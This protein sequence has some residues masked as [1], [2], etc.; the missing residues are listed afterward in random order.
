[1]SS[2][3]TPQ[4]PAGTA[5]WRRHL[6]LALL[7]LSML[8]SFVDRNLLSTMFGPL[9]AELQLSDAQL[10]FLSGVAF[11]V[12]NAI[13]GVSMGYMADRYNRKVLMSTAV[14]LWSL[15]TALQGVCTSYYELVLMR[16]MVGIGEAA[17]G[18]VAHSVICDLFS[19]ER[20]AFAFS[21]WNTSIPVGALGGLLLGGQLTA[22][23]GWRQVFIV[24]G[25]PGLGLALLIAVFAYEPP[26]GV[27]ERLQRALP[28]EKQHLQ[29][30]QGDI[31]EQEQDQLL[32]GDSVLTAP[33]AAAAVSN[34][35]S[36]KSS[37]VCG[38]VSLAVAHLRSL[39]SSWHLAMGKALLLNVAIGGFAW[40]P[41]M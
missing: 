38:R 28:A 14:A 9:S 4:P 22:H 19:P 1:M 33:G 27:G 13:F 32:G 41:T 26:R 29:Q 17:A 25:L 34:T 23:L 8:A 16:M 39:R 18:P 30:Q 21:I 7:T 6:T 10:G 15:F 31:G 5:E 24:V 3:P 37:S 40:M 12:A 2:S 20:R 35:A 11:S 36:S